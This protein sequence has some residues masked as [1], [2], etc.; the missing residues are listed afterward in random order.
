[1]IGCKQCEWRCAE[2][3]RN[4]QGQQRSGYSLLMAHY[5]REHGTQPRHKL[6]YRGWEQ[7]PT[8]A[9]KVDDRCFNC[10]GKGCEGCEP[11]GVV[12]RWNF[13]TLEKIDA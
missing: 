8:Y 5:E 3:V 6:G 4:A 1:M 9:A 2:W 12:E 7:N 10:N 11:S 13:N